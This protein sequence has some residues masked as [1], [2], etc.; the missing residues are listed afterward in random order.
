MAAA[1]VS[2]SPRIGAAAALALARLGR[3]AEA[4]SLV[5]RVKPSA[6]AADVADRTNIMFMCAQTLAALNRIDDGVRCTLDA[7]DAARTL[8]STY[9][10]SIVGLLAEALAD[11]GRGDAVAALHDALV[12]T[13]AWWD[14]TNPSAA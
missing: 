14:H 11:L 1:F 9:H 5:D 4:A 2:T 10:G 7:L 6:A 3:T 13:A 12:S 8:E